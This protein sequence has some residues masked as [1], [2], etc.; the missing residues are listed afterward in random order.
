MLPT[1]LLIN[2]QNGE[3]IIPKRLPI[4]TQMCAIATE[5][6]TCFQDAIGGT[7]GELDRKLLCDRY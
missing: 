7:Q 1:E 6:I 3:E 2:R 4:N 5:L